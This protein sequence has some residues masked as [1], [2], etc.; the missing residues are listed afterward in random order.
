MKQTGSDKEFLGTLNGNFLRFENRNYTQ[1]VKAIFKNGLKV[2]DLTSRTVNNKLTDIWY[3]N[4]LAIDKQSP[5]EFN[6]KE[7]DGIKELGDLLAKIGID[8]LGGVSLTLEHLK[9]NSVFNQLRPE[10]KSRMRA[11]IKSLNNRQETLKESSLLL[12]LN[13]SFANIHAKFLQ[14]DHNHL[15]VIAK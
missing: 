14:V 6:L 9:R 11:K 4:Y 13:N 15:T 1:Q 12:E 3:E 8:N 2:S 10:Y 7:G 5:S